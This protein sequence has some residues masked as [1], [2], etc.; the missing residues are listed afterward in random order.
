MPYEDCYEALRW[1]SV[2]DIDKRLYFSLVECY[3]TVFKLNNLRFA[4]K[5]TRSYHS[6]KLQ[7]KIDRCNGY[8][9]SC[10]VRIVREWNNLPRYV[11]EAGNLRRLKAT[12]KSH[13]RIS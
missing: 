13:M 9:Y 11:M 2:S 12:L 3:K 5:V 6:Y 4:S 8:K 7:V 1:S 10:F